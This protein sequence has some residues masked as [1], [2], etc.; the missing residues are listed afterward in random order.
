VSEATSKPVDTQRVLQH[1][2]ELFASLSLTEGYQELVRELERKAER[3]RAF[4]ATYALS[5]DGANQRQLDYDRG[6]I[7]A[8]KYIPS[9]IAHSERV[10][11]KL[12][13]QVESEPDDEGSLW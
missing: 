3:M 11:E 8:L 10:L 13:E 4:V 12:D 7:D 9:I 1:R 5:P 6:F 2:A